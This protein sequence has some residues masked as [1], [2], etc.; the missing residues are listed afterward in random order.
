[1]EPIKPAASDKD[2]RNSKYEQLED[3]IRRLKVELFIERSERKSKEM[4]IYM[5]FTTS[6]LL[7]TP[8]CQLVDTFAN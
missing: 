6:H 2:V 5:S 1:M 4:G 7:V 8:K 3:D